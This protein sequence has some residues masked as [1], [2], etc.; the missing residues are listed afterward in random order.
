MTI[1][2]AGKRFHNVTITWNEW[3]RALKL[4]QFELKFSRVNQCLKCP[5]GWVEPYNSLCNPIIPPGG[6]S[7]SRD[8]SST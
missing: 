5:E 3:A 1:Y 4:Q 6:R 2:S 8:V 7:I